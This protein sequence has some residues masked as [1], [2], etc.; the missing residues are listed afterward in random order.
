[1]GVRRLRPGL[2]DRLRR[3]S[4]AHLPAGAVRG[5]GPHDAVGP[6]GPAVRAVRAGRPRAARA[7]AAPGHGA[8]TLCGP[9]GGVRLHPAGP[10]QGHPQG[11]HPGRRSRAGRAGAGPA[12]A[13][14]ARI[15][16]GADWLPGRT[17]DRRKPPAALPGAGKPPGERA[18]EVRRAA[19]GGRVR[20]GARGGLGEHHADRGGQ[21]RRD[22][23]RPPVL[24]HRHEPGGVGHRSDLGDPAAPRAPLSAPQRGLAGQA[25]L[26]RGPGGR[27][28]SPEPAAAGA[29]RGRRPPEQPGPDPLPAVSYRSGWPPVRP[30]EV[31]Q[32]ANRPR[33]RLLVDGHRRASDDHRPLAAADQPRRAAA[34]VERHPRRHV[35]RRSPPR[36]A[37]VRRA[38]QRRH[39]RLS[40]PA[41]A[42]GRPHRLGPGARP[43]R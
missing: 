34:A 33:R 7:A 4:S 29:D 40:R 9:G 43:S 18:A 30:A 23:R 28:A 27:H 6:A 15:R 41:P 8:R 17:L 36:T 42:A 38:L 24:R 32:H 31:P 5:A 22:P 1:M 39:R 13:P 12:D 21:R 2:A 14:A 25:G 11:D 3:L 20:A 37:P 16:T 19:G 10:S 26:R 35:P